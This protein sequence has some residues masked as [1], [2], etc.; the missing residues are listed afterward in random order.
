MELTAAYAE[1]EEIVKA[2]EKQRETHPF[3]V[4]EEFTAVKRSYES[5]KSA[6]TRR[7]KGE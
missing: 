3:Q 6:E 2:T 1:I 7:T 5:G 4:G